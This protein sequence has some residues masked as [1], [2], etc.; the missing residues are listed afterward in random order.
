M[1]SGREYVLWNHEPSAGDSL[2][3]ST[4]NLDAFDGVAVNGTW[5]L[6]IRDTIAGESGALERFALRPVYPAQGPTLRM[7]DTGTPGIPLAL[8]LPPDA[9]PVSP[10][11]KD[12]KVGENPQQ[13]QQ[14]GPKAA[15]G[16]GSDP[17]RNVRGRFPV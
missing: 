5:M 11:D 13:D 6:R 10:A 4:L 14:A 8:R 1:Q 2:R 17:L 15:V 7:A 9:H 16:L 12:N 3:F